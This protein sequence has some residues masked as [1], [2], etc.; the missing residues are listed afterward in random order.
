MQPRVRRRTVTPAEDR[1]YVCSHGTL[2]PLDKINEVVQF[3]S[4]WQINV[5]QSFPY[6]GQERGPRHRLGILDH[7]AV[8]RFVLTF[9]H[10]AGPQRGPILHRISLRGHRRRFPA[11]RV[12]RQPQPRGRIPF[13]QNDASTAQPPVGT[14]PAGPVL[15]AV[16]WKHVGSGLG[17]RRF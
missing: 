17:D 4:G 14:G 9:F 16:Q 12:Q 15:S 13:Q 8:S 11:D 1:L 2:D 7:G 10:I 3:L 5:E 6:L